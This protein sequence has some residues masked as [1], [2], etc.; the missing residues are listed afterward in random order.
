MVLQLLS[1]TLKRQAILSNTTQSDLQRP[2]G[3][4]TTGRKTKKVAQVFARD[5][6]VQRDIILGVFF[7]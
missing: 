3:C 6:K 1:T 7:F 5:V 2:R 4:C